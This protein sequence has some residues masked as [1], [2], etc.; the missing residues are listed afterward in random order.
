MKTATRVTHFSIVS[1]ARYIIAPIV[2]AEIIKR[3]SPS[4]KISQPLESRG[5]LHFRESKLV[6]FV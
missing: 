4:K 1:V 6:K 5:L 3:R 2:T